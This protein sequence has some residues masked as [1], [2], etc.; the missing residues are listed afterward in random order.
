M[1]NG[2]II[3]DTPVIESDINTNSGQPSGSAEPSTVDLG[4]DTT[5]NTDI[6]S[7]G[8]DSSVSPV[9]PMDGSTDTVEVATENATESSTETVETTT[10]DTEMSTTVGGSVS[11]NGIG[12]GIENTL[13]T[14]IKT[15]SSNQLL[16][17]EYATSTVTDTYTVWNKPIEDYTV[18]EGLLLLIFVFLLVVFVGKMVIG[19]GK[20]V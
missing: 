19:G 8:G 16:M 7:G 11:D 13:D 17:D 6:D 10:E 5:A 12:P 20:Y 18:T 14:F 4:D 9:L 1:E 3:S 15:V 2:N